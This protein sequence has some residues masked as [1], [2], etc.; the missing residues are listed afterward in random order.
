M[1]DFMANPTF[2][3]LINGACKLQSCLWA[4]PMGQK[5]GLKFYTCS[6]SLIANK[7]KK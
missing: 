2:C 6:I 1:G 3:P 5:D 7:L 4:I